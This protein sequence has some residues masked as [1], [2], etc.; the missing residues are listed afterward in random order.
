MDFSYTEEQK[1]LKR[2]VKSFTA[3]HSDRLDQCYEKKQFP[4]SVFEEAVDVG[5]GTIIP[6]QYGGHGKGA[7]E[8]SIINEEIG[9]FQTS[10]QLARAINETGSDEQK[11]QYLP[12]LANC[13]YPGAIT[14]SEP[15]TGSSLK[16]METKAEPTENGYI[17]NGKKTHANLGA[18]AGLHKIYAMTEEGLTAFLVEQGN[19][20]IE[21]KTQLD[22]IG[23]RD[24]P[25]YDLE[26]ND[27]EVPERA[28]LGE[29]G[30][31]Y[32][33]FFSTFNFSRVGNASS[34]LGR[35]KRA[36]QKAIEYADR[37]SIDDEN[38]V[39]DFQGIRW[40]IADAYTRLEAASRLR[41]EAAWRIENGKSAALH[42]SMAKL[43][44][45]YASL[46]AISTAIQIT[47]AHG[48]YRDQPFIKYFNDAK[49]LEVAGGSREVMRNVIADN[50][51]G[52]S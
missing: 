52:D 20:G 16:N 2:R 17:L 26:L 38:V 9:L 31:G 48:L 51:L 18:E 10:F 27:C 21:I 50:V 36:L 30:G 46:P 11:K 37:R 34:L 13:E 32:E 4:S 40:M 42:T 49:T 5:P 3:E 1:Q 7:I 41:D 19:P 45:A 47:G 29:V 39:T 12:D 14:I 35:G 33:V 24:M 6:E 44:A 28:V 25:I 15:N 43:M 22:P 8:Y 23:L